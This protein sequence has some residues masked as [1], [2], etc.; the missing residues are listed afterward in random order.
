MITVQAQTT[1]GT[2]VHDQSSDQL[3]RREMISDAVNVLF[4]IGGV[5]RC[6]DPAF[7]TTVATGQVTWMN[8]RVDPGTDFAVQ[9]NEQE[10]IE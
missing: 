10:W 7:G 3:T 8:Y 9:D 4:A 5:I 1:T 6:Q 2:V